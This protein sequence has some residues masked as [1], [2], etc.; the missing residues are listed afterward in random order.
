MTLQKVLILLIVS[1][2]CNSVPQYGPNGGGGG[3]SGGGGSGGG[4]LQA[5]CI[6]SNYDCVPYFNCKDGFIIT[7]GEG[8]IDVR[9]RPEGT[10]IN[11]AY[12]DVPAICCLKPPLN[13]VK[14]CPNYQ[15]CTDY[16]QCSKD[17]FVITDGSGLIDIRT[18]FEPC[19]LKSGSYGTC[20][21]PPP[22]QIQ[23]CPPNS[24]CVSKLEC[25]GQALDGTNKFVDYISKGYWSSCNYRAG[26]GVCCIQKP[27]RVTDPC[28][29]DSLCVLPSQC[30]GTALDGS[31]NFIN[32]I[33]TGSWSHCSKYDK[34]VCCVNPYVDPGLEPA[35][36]CGV[37][38]YHIDQRITNNYKPNEA[39]FGEFPWQAIIFYQNY[40]FV[41]GASLI[42]HKHLITAAHCVKHIQA[43]DI[44]I[45]FGEWQVNSFE[46]P[47]P[48]E[49]RNVQAIYINPKFNPKNVHNDI[50]IL[51]LATP[52]DFKYHINT[53]CLPS[54]GQVFDP[55]TPC[56]ATG[57]G[58][59]S[60]EGTFQHIL[61]KI[62]L[63]FIDPPTCETWLKKTRLGEY[64]KLDSSFICAGGEANKDACF[65][66]GGG[67]LVC[68]DQTTSRYVIVGVTSWGI[69]CGTKDVPGVYA[70][71][72]GFVQWVDEI[73][74]G[75]GQNQQQTIPG[76]GK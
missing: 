39:A 23:T 4:K 16:T 64:F 50:A 15:V 9:I 44:R 57:W 35:V 52:I 59:D 8:L 76:Y 74:L 24:V 69:G 46:E 12:P 71:V 48:Y 11:S 38:N 7:D 22:P 37:R 5:K 51:E 42:S 6:N 18:G 13:P 20:C 61:K 26:D 72:P 32:Y 70:N 66:D 27:P 47:L 75:K 68:K 73:V 49:D 1:G 28:P 67:P 29:G 56:F 40:T 65:G 60:F 53:V 55:Y 3:G 33:S 34:G 2:I 36:G 21:I 17:G 10:C 58:K 19:L 45:R 43:P 30:K 63:P 62:D 25:L 14:A 41:C 31:G 54:K